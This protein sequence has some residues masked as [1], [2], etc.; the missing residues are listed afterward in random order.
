MVVLPL[1]NSSLLQHDSSIAEVGGEAP[2]SMMFSIL[3]PKCVATEHWKYASSGVDVGTVVK[4]LLGM[5]IPHNQ[6]A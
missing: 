3:A 6:S 5:P 1:G 2:R 4:V